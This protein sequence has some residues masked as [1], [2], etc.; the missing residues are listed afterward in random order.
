MDRCD[1]LAFVL[2]TWDELA[3]MHDPQHNVTCW[4]EGG[5]PAQGQPCE[6]GFEEFV[7]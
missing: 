3:A 1:S 7:L 6:A 4:G 5:A 2:N